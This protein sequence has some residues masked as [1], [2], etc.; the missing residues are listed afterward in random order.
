MR[1]DVGEQNA[2][3]GVPIVV[4]VAVRIYNLTEAEYTDRKDQSAR[5]VGPNEEP[6]VVFLEL[7]HQSVATVPRVLS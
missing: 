7:L 1:D 5:N 6:D 2:N 4:H 3:A